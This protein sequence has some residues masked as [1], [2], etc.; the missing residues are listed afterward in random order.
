MHVVSAVAI[1]AD[2]GLADPASCRPCVA[3][4]AFQILVRTI[5]FERRLQ[6][7]IKAP[8]GPAVGVVAALTFWSQALLV[9]IV[10]RMTVRARTGRALECTRYM[11]FFAGH[12]GVLP[13]QRKPGQ[14]VLKSDSFRPSALA[15]AAFASRSE[16]VFVDIIRSVTV[17]TAPS[18]L[19]RLDRTLVTGLAPQIL[20]L[21]P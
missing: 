21:P 15:V 6:V 12:H 4:L 11:T 10:I 7:V 18:G 8:E 2:T 17:N 19:L 13:D 1:T 5:Q 16:A 9:R 14:V 3:G 20:M